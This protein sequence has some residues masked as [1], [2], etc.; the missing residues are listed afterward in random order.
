MSILH[1]IVQEGQLLVSGLIGKEGETLQVPAKGEVWGETW[2]KS[3]VEFPLK[4]TFQVYNGNEKSK[5]YLQIASYKIPIWGF[6]KIEYK[7]YETESNE[8]NINF[9]K[10]KLPISIISETHREKEEETRIYSK[11]EA[12]QVAKEMAKADIKSRLPEDAIIKGEKILHQSID[13]G[14]VTIS[15]HFQIIENIGEGQPIIQGESE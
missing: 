1:D 5:Y 14:K 11:E 7:E 6:G 15:I 3:D 12:F 4:S 2:Y 8:K 10:W 13:N 9:M